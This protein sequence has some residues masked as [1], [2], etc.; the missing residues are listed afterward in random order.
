MERM[1]NM[2]NLIN[3]YHQIIFNENPHT[4]FTHLKII[5]ENQ[6]INLKML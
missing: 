3:A 5:F 1:I 4:D 6:M 2:K